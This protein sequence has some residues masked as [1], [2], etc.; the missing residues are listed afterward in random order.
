MPNPQFTKPWHGIAR[1]T[2]TWNPSVIED[3]CIG[4]GTC[5]TGC[6]R[7]VYRFDFERKKPLVIDPLNCM[8]G[9]TTCANTC[10]AHAIEFPPIE[11][12]LALE[13]LGKVHHAIEDDLMARHEILMSELAIPHK[14]R[15]I[16]VLLVSK[17]SV[18]N[19]V[20]RLILK[21]E[22]PDECFCEFIPGQYI[23]LWQPNFTF[24]SRAYSVAN[25][26][27]GDG[28]IELHIRRVDDGR[29]TAW[30]FSNLKEGDRLNA[31]GPLGNFTMKSA[32]DTSLLFIAGGTGLAPLLSIIRQQVK[33]QPARNMVLLWF[34]RNASS[35]YAI[36][37]LIGLLD[38]A[39]NMSLILAS[40]EL[41]S[42]PEH[43][44]IIFTTGSPLDVLAKHSEIINERD[45]YAAGPAGLLR[46]LIQKLYGMGVNK[47]RIHFD[48]FAS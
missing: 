27:Q 34:G 6:S 41:L 29:F 13:S 1:D 21:P 32:V 16:N 2:I 25:L 18:S 39:Q 15:I 10:P 14:D 42:I 48:S 37:E 47:S 38:Q 5:V 26:A 24:M 20:V 23:E 17:V 36:D 9:C 4:C 30:A 44:R 8:V 7:L 31:R 19:D 33:N 46:E 35:F 45:I 28:Q 43:S 22:N 3:A 40:E 12:I 11:S